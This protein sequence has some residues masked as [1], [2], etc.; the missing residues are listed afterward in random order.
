MGVYSLGKQSFEVNE[1]KAKKAL[2]EGR[3]AGM[4]ST[5]AH[6]KP[7]EF[8]YMRDNLYKF[9]LY[10]LDTLVSKAIIFTSKE[11]DE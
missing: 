4:I 5:L 11:K 10:K 7:K 3:Q 8:K 2:A 9:F 1:L 6:L